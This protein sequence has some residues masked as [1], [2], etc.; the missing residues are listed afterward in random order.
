M[1]EEKSR[2][3]GKSASPKVLKKSEEEDKSEIKK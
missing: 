2:K 3:V 1:S